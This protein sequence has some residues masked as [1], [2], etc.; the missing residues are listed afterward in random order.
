ME[1]VVVDNSGSGE[2]RRMLP[3]DTVARLIENPKNAGFGGAINQAYSAYPAEFLATLNDDAEASPQWLEHLVGALDSD[4]GAGMA[5]SLV[6]LSESNSVDSAGMLVARDG[7]SKQRGHND[8]IGSW[9]SAGDALC[10]SGSAAIYRGKMLERTGLFEESFFLYCEDTD[11]GLRA[12]WAGWRCPFVP[13]A[14]V[15]HNY[16]AS[17]GRASSLKAWLVERNRLRVA[18]R[19]LPGSWLAL[20]PFASALRYFWHV[21]SIFEGRGKAAEYIARRGRPAAVGCHGSSRSLRPLPRAAPS[22]AA[23]ARHPRQHSSP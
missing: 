4:P 3:A 7:S 20:A 18:V 19:C 1:V 11:L 21:I 9:A 8:P 23:A 2:A 6:V 12:R 13:A 5:A 14:T 22:M 10:P 15:R 17:A 16:S